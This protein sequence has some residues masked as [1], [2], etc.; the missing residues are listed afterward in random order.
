M[1]LTPLMFRVGSLKI[2]GEASS[3]PIV[4]L[5][6]PLPAVVEVAEGVIMHTKTRVTEVQRETTDDN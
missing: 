3:E 5:Q 4:T 2:T 6:E 1:T